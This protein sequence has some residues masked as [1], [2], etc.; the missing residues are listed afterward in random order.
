MYVYVSISVIGL[1]YTYTY[2]HIHAVHGYTYIQAYTQTSLQ[3]TY[4]AVYLDHIRLYMIS[5]SIYVNICRFTDGPRVHFRLCPMARARVARSGPGAP[6]VHLQCD[7]QA[8]LAQL[9]FASF[10]VG[11][12]VGP[13]PVI[14]AARQADRLRVC[15]LSPPA[16]PSGRDFVWSLHV[17]PRSE[18]SAWPLCGFDPQRQRTATSM[19]S[20]DLQVLCFRAALGRRKFQFGSGYGQMNM[21]ISP[22]P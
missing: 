4:I 7:R 21:D 2:I 5:D 11:L 6:Q 17:T 15:P 10:R 3:S 18:L 22:G 16:S 8:L 9:G 13:S 20:P 19:R 1:K 14:P 12:P